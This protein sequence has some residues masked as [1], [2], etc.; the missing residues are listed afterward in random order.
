MCQVLVH[1]E[2]AI[3]FVFTNFVVFLT[4][5]ELDEDQTCQRCT[6]LFLLQIVMSACHCGAHVTPVQSAVILMGASL[7]P[8]I[9]ATQ[10]M[11][12]HAWASFTGF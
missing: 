7:V 11:D 10:E 3:F 6:I 8:A 9:L 1:V 12:L 2:N 4:E 5:V